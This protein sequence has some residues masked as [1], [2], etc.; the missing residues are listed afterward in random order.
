MQLQTIRIKKIHI[1]FSYISDS[2]PI[3]IHKCEFKMQTSLDLL[4][5]SIIGPLEIII[6]EFKLPDFIYFL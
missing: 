1:Y 3:F 4:K 5:F 6:S 2:L